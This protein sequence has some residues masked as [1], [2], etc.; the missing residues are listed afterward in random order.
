MNDSTAPAKSSYSP[1]GS[2]PKG[3]NSGGGYLGGL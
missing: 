2:K 3:S 1:F